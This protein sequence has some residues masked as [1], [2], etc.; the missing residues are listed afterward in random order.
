MSFSPT[1]PHPQL[2]YQGKVAMKGKLSW[3]YLVVG[4]CRETTRRHML[5]APNLHTASGAAL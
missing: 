2:L 3:P 5:I 4:L 1:L